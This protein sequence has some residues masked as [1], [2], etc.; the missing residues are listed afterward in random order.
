MQHY[1][2]TYRKC[3]ANDDF[4][5]VAKYIYLTDDYIYPSICPSYD[6]SFFQKLIL[7]CSKDKTNLFYYENLFVALCDDKIIGVLCG[8]KAGEKK[9][10]L[11]NISIT[12]ED[13]KKISS[14]DKGYFIPL[15]DEN[16]EFT[17]Y[18]ITNVCVD[19]NFR[20]MGIGGGLIEFYLS[21]IPD[22]TVHLD[23]IADNMPAIKLYQKH[24]FEIVNEYN[25][26]SGSD[27]PLPCYH[28]IKKPSV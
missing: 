14:A 25:G 16:T 10:F 5:Q 8:I 1:N 11:E 17:G 13:Y 28:M 7:E 18:N 3:K 27:K 19:T 21:Q 6:D 26:F 12:D 24:G 20:A 15:L 9:T 22:S 23:V 4:S 2:I